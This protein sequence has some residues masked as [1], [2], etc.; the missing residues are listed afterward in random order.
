[1]STNRVRICI[2]DDHNIVRQGLRAL[3][4]TNPRY[5]VVAEAG[6][7]IQAIEIARTTNPDLVIL[8]HKMPKLDGIDA[9]AE[10]RRA[11]ADAKIVILS[12]HWDEEKVKS[13][14]LN[15]ANGYL[16]KN[17]DFKELEIAIESVLSGF[18]YIT[19][20]VSHVILSPYI[21]KEKITI[22]R[23]RKDLLSRRE[24][25]VL[26][27]ITEGHRSRE[28]AGLLYISYTTVLKHRANLMAKLG[29]HSVAD[30]IAY[31]GRNS[32]ID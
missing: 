23:S 19:P 20:V 16:L 10:I 15:G 8:D 21:G 13:A 6:D 4:S 9:I 1:M 12:G 27:L 7:G 32:L 11:R 18:Y 28:I 14:F 30:L 2:A 22:M 24:R 31:A 29:V 25:Q 5:L 26:K 3:L 17:C